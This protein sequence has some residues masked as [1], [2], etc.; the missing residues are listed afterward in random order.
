[1]VHLDVCF[2]KSVI[3][4]K[5]LIIVE[6]IVVVTAAVLAIVAVVNE[7]FIAYV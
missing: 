3:A 7:I 4:G 2:K 5:T 6:V 1:M